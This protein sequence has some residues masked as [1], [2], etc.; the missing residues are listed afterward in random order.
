[1]SRT[2][3]T[4]SMISLPIPASPSPNTPIPLLSCFQD[5]TSTELLR[6][7]NSWSCPACHRPTPT[8]KTLSIV[9]LPPLLILHL[10]R[11]RYDGR[12]KQ[13]IDNE[14]QFDMNNLSLRNWNAEKQNVIYDLYGVA[15]HYGSLNGGHCKSKSSPTTQV[16]E[17]LKKHLNLL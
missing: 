10:K 13:K 17:S 12:W 7:E 16:L 5:F 11:F 4:F 15:N 3:S 6:G 1:M 9:K 2:F 8:E 14:I